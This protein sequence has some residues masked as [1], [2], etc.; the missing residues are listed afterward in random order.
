MALTHFLT[1]DVEDW[2]QSTLNFDLPIT[3]RAADNMRRLL[4]ILR[5]HNVRA[6]MFVQ[7]MFAEAFPSLVAEMAA[8]GHEIATHGYSHRP[9]YAIGADAFADELKRSVAILEACT[10]HPV[11][12]YRAPDFSVRSDTPWAFD[13]LHAAGLRYDSSIFPVRTPRYGIPDAPRH[14]H[15]LPNGLLEI[16]LS[17]IEWGGRRW[18][19][20]GGGYFRLLPYAITRRAIRRLEAEGIPA[21]VYLHPYELDPDELS[22]IPHHVPWRLRL[23]QGLGRHSVAGKL[24]ALLRE[25]TFA[26]IAEH[27]PT[28][29]QRTEA[30]A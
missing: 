8:E 16:P 28:L 19:V 5:R 6:T 17:T 14:A 30:V 3:Q 1:I 10:G 2:P 24:D 21:V 25:F 27:L 22:S 18:P 7:G 11:Q 26:P 4:E 29:Q 9:V 12:G 13:I 23:S 15:V 20:A